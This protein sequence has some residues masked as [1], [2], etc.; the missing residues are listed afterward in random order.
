MALSPCKSATDGR[1]REL[2][3]HGTTAFPLACYR[4]DGTS[5][6]AVPWHWHGE[7]EAIWMREGQVFVSVEGETRTLGPGEGCFITAGA[8]HRVWG[9]GPAELHS[10]VFHPR[11]VGG[12]VESVFWQGYLQPLLDSAAN[13]CVWLSGEVPWQREA[14]GALEG[15]WRACEEEPPGFEFRAREGL[16]RLV[17]LLSGHRPAERKG[18]SGKALRDGSRM[19]AM[20]RYV[21]DHW[22]EELT[23]AA[24][25]ESAAVSASECF[26][27]FRSVIGVT[28]V[29]YVKQLRIERAAELLAATDE[30]VSDIGAQ[31]GFQEMS[32]FARTFRAL[33]GETPSRYRASRRSP[34]P[35]EAG[36]P[37]A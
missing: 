1:S 13:R 17:F 9:A 35:E 20:L 37:E 30:P 24:I 25:A 3:R 32:Y 28:P 18:P 11:L 36:A 15:A 22:N 26:R 4:H 6:N 21:Q 14:L 12:S 31:C 8:L 16:S 23:V 10:L 5:V 7:L 19:K 34:G 27:C 29:Q 33:K 2:A